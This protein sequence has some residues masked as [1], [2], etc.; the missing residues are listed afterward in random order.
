MYMDYIKW[1]P[2]IRKVKVHVLLPATLL[3]DVPHLREKTIR[4]SM[5][6]RALSM[7]RVDHIIIYKD[8][9]D[10]KWKDDAR[11]LKLLLEYF[12]TPP[13]LKRLLFKKHSNLRYVGVA[14]P[15][16][17]P[18]HP[19]HQLDFSSNFRLA[20][21]IKK[22]DRVFAEAGL[23]KPI[24]IKNGGKIKNGELVILKVAR[25]EH[26][27]IYGEI[28]D[29]LSIQ[30]YW[31]YDVSIASDLVLL[32]KNLHTQNSLI[33]STSRYGDDIRKIIEELQESLNRSQNIALIFGSPKEGLKEI[34]KRFGLEVTRDSDYVVNFIPFQ[35]VK[36]VRTEE[37][38]ISVL[39]IINILIE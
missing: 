16:K 3:R 6:A 20:L 39:S 9:N 21:V 13:Y 19:E 8:V 2:P 36:T 32:I 26:G 18:S 15:L 10:A 22:G 23:P 38:L 4:A 37:A 17:A 7:F 5:I 25:S 33:I 31:I 12:K 14:P 11:L 24:E 34:F 30:H 35:G 29:P 28:V 1:P 27:N